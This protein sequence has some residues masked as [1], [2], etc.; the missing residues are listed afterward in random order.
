MN[1][2]YCGSPGPCNWTAPIDVIDSPDAIPP[3]LDMRPE[4]DVAEDQTWVRTF[5]LRLFIGMAAI[6]GLILFAL[7]NVK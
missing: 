5:Y 4:W 6:V 2:R 1:C 7:I 3:C